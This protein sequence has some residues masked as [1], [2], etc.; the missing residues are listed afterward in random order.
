VNLITNAAQANPGKGT[1][2]IAARVRG[3]RVRIEVKD[4]G[5]GIKPEHLARLFEPFFTT[6]EAGRGTGLGLALTHGIVEKHGGTIEGAS[7]PGKGAV[8]TIELP[9]GARVEGPGG[10]PGSSALLEGRARDSLAA[11]AMRT[12]RG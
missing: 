12:R 6:K 8:F 7:E 3:D 10:A 4:D 2:A 11:V 1:I 9:L 5:P